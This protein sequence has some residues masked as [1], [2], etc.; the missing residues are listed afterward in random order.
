MPTRHTPPHQ[1]R[2]LGLCTA[3]GLALSCLNPDI[4]D[5]APITETT[6]ALEIPDAGRAALEPPGDSD[7]DEED[8][9]PSDD[10]TDTTPSDDPPQP[11]T[12]RRERGRRN[13]FGR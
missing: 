2:F 13:P 11:Q 6:A 5:E 7:E 12:D 3:F 9:A 1:G 10:D 8:D 4:S